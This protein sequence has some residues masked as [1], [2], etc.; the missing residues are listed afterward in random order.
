MAGGGG[1]VKKAKAASAQPPGVPGYEDD[2]SCNDDHDIVGSYVQPGTG[3][4]LIL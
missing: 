1:A 4:C 2:Y 3:G